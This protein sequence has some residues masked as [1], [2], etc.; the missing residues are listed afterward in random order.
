MKYVLVTGAYGGMGKAM[1]NSLLDKGFFVIA[2]DKAIEQEN[3]ERLF[4]IEVDI[5]K[6]ENIQLALKKIKE[7]TN[8]LDA[9]I[10][11]TGIYMLDSLVEIKTDD[12]KKIFD[13]NFFGPVLINKIFI[14][15]LQKGSKI[16]MVTSEL[17]P[18][19]PLPFTGIYAITK[20]SLD[21][22]AYS[23]KME[24]QLLGISVS[25]LR[26][27]AVK[28]NMLDTSTKALDDFCNNTKLY[29]C[30]A[31]RFKNIVDGVE[32]KSIEPNKIA[33]LV[34]KIIYKKKPSFSYSLNNNVFL[35][36]LNI[37][38]HKFQFWIIKQI[39]KTKKEK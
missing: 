17:A 1:V 26:A 4:S 10:H 16:I 11:F 33:K 32:A 21:K 35:K 27:G 25:V 37:L 7:I 13:I 28:T 39:L 34:M 38:P 29:S 31:K 15:M 23:L 22:Y 8:T 30:N 9:I 2:L 36:L 5:T 18:L 20:S 6:E 19:D 12:L 14:S 24:L 3:K